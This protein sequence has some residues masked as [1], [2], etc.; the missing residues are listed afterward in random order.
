MKLEPQILHNTQKFISEKLGGDDKKPVYFVFHGGSGSSREDIQSAFGV[1]SSVSG[2]SAGTR[3]AAAAASRI[4]RGD[5]V[6]A[7]RIVRK[8]GSRRRRGAGYSAGTSRGATAAAS[9][10]VRGDES[11]RRRLGRRSHRQRADV[12]CRRRA[13]DRPVAA[14]TRSRRARSR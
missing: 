7:S 2:T 11:R 1:G 8:D 10:I 3:R 5:A 4:V 9:Q 13:H 6:A 14:G 12:R